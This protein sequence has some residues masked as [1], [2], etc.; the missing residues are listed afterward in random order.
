LRL[1]KGISSF[2]QPTIV[3]LFA[4]EVAVLSQTSGLPPEVSNRKSILKR[5][6]TPR[7]ASIS[8]VERPIYRRVTR[9]ARLF[10]MPLLTSLAMTAKLRNSIY[11]QLKLQALAGR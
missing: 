4:G 8:C 6:S 7:A 5:G 11:R 10:S 9:R 1:Q 3:S 2:V